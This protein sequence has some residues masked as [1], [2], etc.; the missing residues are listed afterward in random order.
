MSFCITG[1]L[2]TLTGPGLLLTGSG[3][4]GSRLTGPWLTGPW[5]TGPGL[6][7]PWLAG[8]ASF[9]AG[10]FGPCKLSIGIATTDT[11]NAASAR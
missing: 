5:L 4:T 7:G 6:T 1:L 11:S 3:L 8:A 10:G 9:L 2:L